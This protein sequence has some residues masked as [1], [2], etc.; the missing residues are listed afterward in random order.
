LLTLHRAL[1]VALHPTYYHLD[2]LRQAAT[3]LK[4][5]GEELALARVTQEV[6]I[7]LGSRKVA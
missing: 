3:V 4:N 6:N 7:R 1:I 5:T 2:T